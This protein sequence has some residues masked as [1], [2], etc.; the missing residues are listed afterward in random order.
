MDNQIFNIVKT[1]ENMYCSECDLRKECRR[2]DNFDCG[3][4][5]LMN[6]IKNLEFDTVEEE[7]CYICE[8]SRDVFYDDGRGGLKIAEFCP[9]C[10]RKLV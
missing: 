4:K 1:I 8:K 5:Y 10:G 3:T 2:N 9:N 7:G 6:M